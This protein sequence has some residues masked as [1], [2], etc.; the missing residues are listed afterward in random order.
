[1]PEGVKERRSP[2]C[3]GSRRALSHPSRP[4][5][6]R[7]A[8]VA[9]WIARLTPNQEVASSNL[10]G[11]AFPG[12]P[13]TRG[14]AE[15]R[16]HGHGPICSRTPSFK[17]LQKMALG[18][19]E[20]LA[21]DGPRLRA[22]LQ[23]LSSQMDDVCKAVGVLQSKLKEET[24]TVGGLPVLAAKNIILAKYLH[25]LAAFTEEKVSGTLLLDKISPCI[26]EAI[27]T[28]VLYDKALILEKRLS[29]QIASMLQSVVNDMAA[30]VHRAPIER[31]AA[32]DDL[33]SDSDR[34]NS[35]EEPLDEM[36]ERKQRQSQEEREAVSNSKFRKKRDMD[37]GPDGPSA[38]QLRDAA[39]ST[40]R[41]V[42]QG[43]VLDLLDYYEGRPSEERAGHGRTTIGRE[44][45]EYE[46]ENYRRV[47]SGKRR[48]LEKK[49]RAAE[50][51]TEN[52]L[53]STLANDV[54]RMGKHLDYARSNIEDTQSKL[55]KLV[56]STTRKA[57]RDSKRKRKA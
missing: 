8:P 25:A 39:I 49:A 21:A 56:D 55:D 22:A 27:E 37:A 34:N 4:P 35:H 1:M 54:I 40:R 50:D 46:M 17:S 13:G 26:A 45:D 30:T 3:R 12:R 32:I 53:D 29:R 16:A 2:V 42:K 51:A 48:E 33:L 15:R 57:D 52:L 9:Q 24:R 38:Q 23:G 43:V 44:L 28:R 19:H 6:R 7:H 47:S 10:A 14:E 20:L 11:G 41:L 5:P 31:E 18:E 36:V